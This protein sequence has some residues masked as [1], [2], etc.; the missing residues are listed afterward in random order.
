MPDEAEAAF[1]FVGEQ[2]YRSN[3]DLGTDQQLIEEDEDGSAS[4]Q[5]SARIGITTHRALESSMTAVLDVFS[6]T[7]TVL[8]VDSVLRIEGE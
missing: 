8:G 4:G 5:G 6:S 2:P 1:T 3:A 7:S